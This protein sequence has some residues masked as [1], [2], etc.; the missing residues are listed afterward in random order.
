[1][2]TMN[3]KLVVFDIAGTTVR[4]HGHVADAFIDAFKQH[5]KEVSRDDVSHLMGFRKKDAI[6]ILLEKFPYAHHQN[7]E[8]IDSIHE[9]FTRNIIA[10]YETDDSISALP[11]A[12]AI[13]Q[14]LQQRGIRIALNTGF[15]RV[16]TD[17]ILRKLGWQE[18]ITVDKV[19]C[20]DEVPQ[21][22]PH[23]YMIQSI[24]QQLQVEDSKA[25][26]KVGDTQVDV[27]EGRNAGCG[28]VISVTSGAY[29]RSELEPFHPDHIIDSLAEL[30]SLI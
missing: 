28:L 30:Q 15:T 17:T 16:V 10:A 11:E 8:L 26:V 7:G 23:P 25:V 4:D 29:T 9:A 14:W 3:T 1:M 5:N 6:R 22:R 2:Y 20:S 24:M 21:G 13:F 18:G 19:I 27:E 12:E